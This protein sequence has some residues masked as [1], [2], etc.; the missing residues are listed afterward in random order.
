MERPQTV[1]WSKVCLIQDVFVCM[2]DYHIENQIQPTNLYTLDYIGQFVALLCYFTFF[3][4]NQT[5]LLK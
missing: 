5:T 4:M 1:C 2:F 3:D